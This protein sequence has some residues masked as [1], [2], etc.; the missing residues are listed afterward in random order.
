MK[1]IPILVIIIGGWIFYRK[2]KINPTDDIYR[3][4]YFLTGIAAITYGCF[5]ILLDFGFRDYLIEHNLYL[6]EQFRSAKMLLGGIC[7]GFAIVYGFVEEKLK[8]K[9]KKKIEN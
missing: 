9:R 8:R 2:R 6:Y 5:G 4:I 3:I 7:I 1:I